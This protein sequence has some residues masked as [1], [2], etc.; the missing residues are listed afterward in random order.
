MELNNG[1]TLFSP[2]LPVDSLSTYQIQ[3]NDAIIASDH[4]PVVG[5]FT[6]KTDPTTGVFA[7]RVYMSALRIYPNPSNNEIRFEGMKND[8]QFRCIIY[9]ATGKKIF[10]LKDVSSTSTINISELNSGLYIATTI[11]VKESF[12]GKF[13]KE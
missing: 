8:S 4:L 5:D 11:G 9:D 3:K 7:P 2:G 10:D 1:Y 6:L 12:S 13:R